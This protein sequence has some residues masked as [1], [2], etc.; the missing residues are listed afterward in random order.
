M[1]SIEAEARRKPR[2]GELQKIILQTV[3]VAG[4]I[5]I[6]LVAPNV[7]GAMA[8]LGLIASKRQAGLVGRACERLLASG[9]MTWKRGQLCLTPRGEAKLLRLSLEQLSNRKPRRWD[10]RWRVLIFDIPESSKYL[11]DKVRDTLRAIGFIRLQHSVWIY[12]YDC[13]DLVMLLKADLQVGR[14]LLY[15]VVDALENDDE[16]RA[17]FRL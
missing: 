3:K 13:E 4:L 11:R 14:D 7:I 17:R 6:L 12:P 2:R 9:D 16:L 5:S 15:M 8:K 1:G 10:K